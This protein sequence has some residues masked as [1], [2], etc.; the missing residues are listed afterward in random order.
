[1]AR[2]KRDKIES[3]MFTDVDG[4]GVPAS[5][6]DANPAVIPGILGMAAGLAHQ[7]SSSGDKEHR[8]TFLRKV[9]GSVGL[10]GMTAVYAIAF[11]GC[12]K[13]CDCEA[14]CGCHNVGSCSCHEVCSCN[15]VCSCEA[16]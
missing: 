16:V 3:T 4:T 14:V 7:D 5:R 10:V 1:M 9:A 11:N 2:V 8:R 6:P 13:Q 12:K 15:K